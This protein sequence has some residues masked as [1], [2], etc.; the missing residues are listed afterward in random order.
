MVRLYLSITYLQ[1]KE[2]KEY[3][4]HNS[5]HVVWTMDNVIM[6]DKKETVGVEAFLRESGIGFL[7]Y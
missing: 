6:V 1:M 3:L 7:E 4:F 2:L 5:Y